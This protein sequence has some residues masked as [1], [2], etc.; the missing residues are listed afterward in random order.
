[1]GDYIFYWLVNLTFIW[2]KYIIKV[3]KENKSSTLRHEK[4]CFYFSFVTS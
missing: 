4:M 1:M 3:E 2:S